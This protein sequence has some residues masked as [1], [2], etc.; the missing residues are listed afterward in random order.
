MLGSGQ[1]YTPGTPVVPETPQ[2]G[3]VPSSQALLPL[4]RTHLP[5]ISRH[6]QRML[7]RSVSLPKEQAMLHLSAILPC[8]S[9]IP[10]RL[11]ILY[12]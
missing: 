1:A 9:A 5:A 3:S 6:G 2:I 11:V 4:T 10:R 8:Q 12:R 7:R